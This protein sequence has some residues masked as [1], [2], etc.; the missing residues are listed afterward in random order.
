MYKLL[1]LHYN[2]ENITIKVGMNWVKVTNETEAKSSI[3]LWFLPV[4]RVPRTQVDLFI[5]RLLP[6]SM[7]VYV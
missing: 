6:D 4:G 1:S 5:A 3:W 2:P 7:S